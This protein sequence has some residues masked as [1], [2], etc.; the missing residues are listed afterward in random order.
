MNVWA[1]SPGRGR[2]VIVGRVVGVEVGEG[3]SVAVAVGAGV[4]VGAAKGW[5]QALRRDVM[6]MKPTRRAGGRF[7]GL[8]CTLRETGEYDSFVAVFGTRVKLIGQIY[9]N[10]F[11][12]SIF[13]AARG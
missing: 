13:S 2:G 7:I 4:E 6:M 12:K 1:M 10:F 3:V 5:T 11:I 8:Y 9:A